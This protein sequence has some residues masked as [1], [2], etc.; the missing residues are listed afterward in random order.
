[1]W[2]LGKNFDEVLIINNAVLDTV[3][4]GWVRWMGEVKKKC[5][6]SLSCLQRSSSPASSPLHAPYQGTKKTIVSSL[7]VPN[8]F[9]NSAVVSLLA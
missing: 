3:V 5:S 6:P 2:D 4:Y 8:Y 1:M 9:N 7:N